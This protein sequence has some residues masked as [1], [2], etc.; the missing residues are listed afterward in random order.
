[1]HLKTSNNYRRLQQP[2]SEVGH[3]E[4]RLMDRSISHS[5][6]V[7]LFDSDKK[8]KKKNK[9]GEQMQ[10]QMTDSQLQ[11]IQDRDAEIAQLEVSDLHVMNSKS[12]SFLTDF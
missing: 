3:L 4:M 9:S 6:Q 2:D 1:M 10:S 5:I 8:N 11:A 12:L 7:K